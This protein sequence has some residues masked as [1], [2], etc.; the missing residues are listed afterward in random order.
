MATNKHNKVIPKA[1][2]EKTIFFKFRTQSS[3]TIQNKDGLIYVYNR[4]IIGCKI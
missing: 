4:V 1:I 2:D 3:C